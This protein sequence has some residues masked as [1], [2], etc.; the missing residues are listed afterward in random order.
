MPPPPLCQR[1]PWRKGILQLPLTLQSQWQKHPK[2]MPGL[3]PKSSP[4]AKNTKQMI[5]T[6]VAP[7]EQIQLYREK[8]HQTGDAMT[9]KK[10]KLSKLRVMDTTWEEIAALEGQL[11]SLKCSYRGRRDVVAWATPRATPDDQGGPSG[12]IRDPG[13]GQGGTTVSTHCNRRRPLSERNCW[14]GHSVTTCQGPAG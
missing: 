1:I 6:Q 7:P 2:E 8:L 13:L 5:A 3:R 4:L 12:G 10:T 9:H 14:N 11:V